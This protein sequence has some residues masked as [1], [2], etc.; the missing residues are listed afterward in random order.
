MK[1]TTNGDALP[2]VEFEDEDEEESKR[3]Y[4]YN[5]QAPPVD[6]DSIGIN[7]N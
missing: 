1:Q 5:D 6:R 2:K 4:D 7:L 3:P